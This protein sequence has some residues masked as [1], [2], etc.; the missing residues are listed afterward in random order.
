MY[1]MIRTRNIMLKDWFEIS[2]V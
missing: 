1:E 2:C